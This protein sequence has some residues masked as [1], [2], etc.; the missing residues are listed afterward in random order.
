MLALLGHASADLAQL[1]CYNIGQSLSEDYFSLCSPQI[2]ITEFLFGNEEDLQQRVN[3]I[4]ASNKISKTT[5]KKDFIFSTSFQGKT[6]FKQSANKAFF[7]AELPTKEPQPT[8]AKALEKA[9]LTGRG[10]RMMHSNS[11]HLQ[12]KHKTH[13]FNSFNVS[14]FDQ[15]YLDVLKYSEDRQS[16]FEGGCIS[17]SLPL[18]KNL[19][20]DPEILQMVTGL[21]I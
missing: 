7:R 16:Y 1:R 4:A 3:G 20:K 21:Q 14:N 13:N 17:S 6:Y 11:P 9:R 19:T 2:P 18:W 5:A 12:W 8:E 10:G 15:H